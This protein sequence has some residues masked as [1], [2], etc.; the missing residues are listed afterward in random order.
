MPHQ[1]TVR[2]RRNRATLTATSR[3]T[4]PPAHAGASLYHYLEAAWQDGRAPFDPKE[5]MKQED[6]RHANPNEVRGLATVY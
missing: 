1:M 5:L 4:L 6:L 3:M 2:Q